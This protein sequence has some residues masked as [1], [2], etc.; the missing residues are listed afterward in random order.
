MSSLDSSSEEEVDFNE[1]QKEYES[2]EHWK[3]RKSFMEAFW[4]E[5]ET[6]DEVLVSNRLL[7]IENSC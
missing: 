6:E 4:D 2:N 1:Y 7:H 5:M 3:L